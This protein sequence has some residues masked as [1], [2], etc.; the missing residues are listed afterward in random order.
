MATSL[1]NKSSVS[2]FLILKEPL[3]HRQIFLVVCDWMSRVLLYY[4]CELIQLLKKYALDPFI[5]SFVSFHFIW[6]ASVA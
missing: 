3:L 6:E 4:I 1:P 2:H 5:F